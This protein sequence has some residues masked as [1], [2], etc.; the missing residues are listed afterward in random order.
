MLTFEES[1]D[2]AMWL[3]LLSGVVV[4]AVAAGVHTIVPARR[5]LCFSA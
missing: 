4:F 2:G 1:D 5:S 3:E